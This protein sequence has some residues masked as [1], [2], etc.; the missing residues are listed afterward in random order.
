MWYSV[1]RGAYNGNGDYC[2]VVKTL[3]Y[4]LGYNW[5]A[6]NCFL[7]LRFAQETAHVPCC[8]VL[9]YIHDYNDLI[10]FSY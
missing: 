10:A 8:L 5:I 4:Y 9:G 3:Q 1:L 6:R 7:L 2:A